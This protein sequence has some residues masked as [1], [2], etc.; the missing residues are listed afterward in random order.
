MENI[1]QLPQEE[2][3]KDF[4]KFD[5]ITVFEHLPHMEDRHLKC[6]YCN[7]KI[8]IYY[9]DDHEMFIKV[10]KDKKCGYYT[11]NVFPEPT[12]VNIDLN[13]VVLPDYND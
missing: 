13:S 2:I 8:L 7:K 11:A 12:D 6:P 10:C 3:F 5:K 9:N 4:Y 1:K